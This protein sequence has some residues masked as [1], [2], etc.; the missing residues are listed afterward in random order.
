MYVYNM[1]ICIATG[2]QHYYL[3]YTLSHWLKGL[4]IYFK[5]LEVLLSAYDQF[6]PNK[7]KI[8]T[9]PIKYMK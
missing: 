7:L 8:H 2:D 6:V 5:T 3:T 4:Y 9:K 1:Y